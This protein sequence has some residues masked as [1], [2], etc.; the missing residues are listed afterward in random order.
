MKKRFLAFE[1]SL[2]GERL[3]IA[4]LP[5]AR[6]L[7]TALSWS[8]SS[9]PIRL[10]KGT[11]LEQL[12]LHVGALT[13]SRSGATAHPN[14]VA[15]SKLKV[16]DTFSVRIIGTADADPPVREQ[17]LSPEEAREEEY[18]LYLRLKRR[19]GQSKAKRRARPPKHGRAG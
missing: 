10:K 15:H 9:Q 6:V 18:K 14:W 8:S 13:E 3:C 11:V 16:G 19:V 12:Y 5:D 4:G 1:V 7:S 17:R 2:N